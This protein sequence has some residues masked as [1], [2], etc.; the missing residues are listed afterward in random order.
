MVSYPLTF[1]AAILEQNNCPLVIDKVEF[2]GPLLPGQILV[3]VHYSGICGKQLEEIKGTMGQDPYLPHML[4]HEGSGIVID[5]GPAVTKVQPGDH[6]VLH[7]LKGSG[8]DAST[9]IYKRK[10]NSERINAGWI[11]TFNEYAIVPENRITKISKES[12]L[13]IACL[14][15]CAVTTGLGVIFNEANVRPAESVAIF[16]CGGVGLC[17]IQGAKNVHAYPIIAIDK[18]EENLILAKKMGATHLLNSEKNISAEIK[19]L[20]KNCGTYHTIVTAAYP[21]VIETAAA[22]TSTPGNIFI[23]GVPRKEA[24]VTINVLDIHR[25]KMFTGSYGGGCVPDK[26]IPQYITLYEQGHLQLK[27]LI[28]TTTSLHQINECLG[29]SS[30]KTTPPGRCIIKMV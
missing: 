23:V 20:T 5:I 26:D 21:S 1:N 27:E 30:S 7:W 9:P 6:V 24:T 11:T 25:R 19:N 3:R 4:G 28:T 8:M 13:S 10:N 2:T 29:F 18:N 15:G 17:S 16:G 14:L 12:D 22:S